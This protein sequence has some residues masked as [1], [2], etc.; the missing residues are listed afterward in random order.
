[1][2]SLKLRFFRAGNDWSLGVSHTHYAVQKQQ[3]LI[4]HESPSCKLWNGKRH[5]WIGH[6]MRK[7]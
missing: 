4:C 3:S 6:S 2:G 7:L 5:L 1:M